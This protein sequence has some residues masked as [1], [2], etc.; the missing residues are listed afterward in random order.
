MRGC[1]GSSAARTAGKPCTPDHIVYSKSFPLVTDNITREKIQEFNAEHGYLPR[2]ILVPGKVLFAAGKNVSAMRTAAD[3][4][5]DSCAI[6]Q[7]SKAF[8]GAKTL[9]DKARKFIENWEME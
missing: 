8:G 6:L 4:I 5:M 9:S 3:F 1:D 7:L 2:A